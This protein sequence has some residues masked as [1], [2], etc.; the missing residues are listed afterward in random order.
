M[1][2]SDLD[3]KTLLTLHVQTILFGRVSKEIPEYQKALTLGLIEEDGS[4]SPE[5]KNAM[6]SEVLRRVT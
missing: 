5:I 1:K 3:S 6:S 4:V 2:F